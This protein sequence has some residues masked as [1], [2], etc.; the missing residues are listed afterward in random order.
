MT[1]TT[2]KLL[3]PNVRIVLSCDADPEC[4]HDWTGWRLVSFG[5]RHPTYADPDRY[6]AGL[7]ARG[8]PIPAQVGLRRRLAVG[9]AFWLSYYEHGSCRWSLIDEGARCP[10]DGVR[11]AGILLWEGPKR[12][13]PGSRLQRSEYARK[14]LDAYTAWSNGETFRYLITSETGEVLDASGGHVDPEAMFQE[15]R[16]VVHGLT[17]AVEGDAS[18]LADYHVI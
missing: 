7:D 9:T 6:Y 8:D 3:P 4:P 18:W 17:V 12:D 2:L 5:R 15:I 14:F 10:W 16:R 11:L 13:L 1:H